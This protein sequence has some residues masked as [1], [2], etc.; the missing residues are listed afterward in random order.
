MATLYEILGVD[1][2][3]TPFEIVAAHDALVAKLRMQPD[4]HGHAAARLQA[5][6]HAMHILVDPDRRLD[7]DAQLG[8]PLGAWHSA[9]MDEHIGPILL[10]RDGTFVLGNDSYSQADAV[11]IDEKDVH[12]SKQP[13]ERQLL[14]FVC[15]DTC[16]NFKYVNGQ[17]LVWIRKHGSHS[18][19]NADQDA[20]P[21]ARTRSS[22]SSSVDPSKPKSVYLSS[23]PPPLPQAGVRSRKPVYLVGAGMLM[24]VILALGAWWIF[25]PDAKPSAALDQELSDLETQRK[26]NAE[27]RRLLNEQKELAELESELGQQ[28]QRS[29]AVRT[30]LIAAQQSVDQVLAQLAE[31]EGEIRAWEE[32]VRPLMQNA[33]GK[34]LAG[35]P[36]LVRTFRTLFEQPLPGTAD[37]GLLR[38]RVESLAVPIR[39]ELAKDD[40]RIEPGASLTK[41]LETCLVQSRELAQK[42]RGQR[43]QLESLVASAKQSAAPA[44][45][46]LEQ[47]LA[48]LTLK[49]SQEKADRIA[50]EEDRVRKVALERAVKDRSQQVAEELEQEALKKS[51]EALRRKRELEH[52]VRIEKAQAKDV[53]A[54]LTPFIA[55][56]YLQPDDSQTVDKRPYSWKRLQLSGALDPSEAGLEKLRKLVAYPGDTERPR[57]EMNTTTIRDLTPAQRERLRKAQQALIEYGEAL[58]ELKK[59]DP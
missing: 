34:F 10:R 47:A 23:G 22:V 49:E 17:W 51:A 32:Q 5:A 24:A 13:G 30:Q 18:T 26:I 52:Q 16:A 7:Y 43:R 28:K 1:S 42:V 2:D 41:E 59:L 37:A 55:G 6:R 8:L 46:T 19:Q 39:Q 9:P 48:A 36:D 27:R 56:G 31:L 11:R 25:G 40:P 33:E 54:L 38:S 35:R 4:A 45:V 58:V 44:Q 50:V 3:V 29:A 53:L 15:D 14:R 12:L 57:W 20:A 21:A